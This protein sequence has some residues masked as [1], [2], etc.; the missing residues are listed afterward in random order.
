M[1]VAYRPPPRLGLTPTLGFPLGGWKALLRGGPE[2][3]PTLDQA[4]CTVESKL[5]RIAYLRDA[6]ALEGKSVLLLGDDDL[7]AAAIPFAAQLLGRRPPARLAAVDVDPDVIA[8]SRA[9]LAR[10]GLTAELVVH[11]L[12]RPLPDR[13][14]RA[15]DTVLTDP[16]YTQA[17]VE[18]FL[19]R[20]AD[21]LRQG[22][23]GQAFLCLGPKPPD[24]SALL[25]RA[26]IGMG[27]SIHR[28]VRNFND[29]HGR[30]WVGVAALALLDRDGPTRPPPQ[31]G[32][33]TSARPSPQSSM[34]GGTTKD[35]KGPGRSA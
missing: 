26:I 27:F 6:G 30:V 25:Q 20:A 19:S 14:L 23:G 24:E 4:H 32:E 33:E 28:L 2:A 1:P 3:D 22:G 17:G 29:Y 35:E 34:P 16:P 9:A 15:F 31:G 5:R 12:R 21:G 10:V 11:D 13:L 18:L 7:M 8:F